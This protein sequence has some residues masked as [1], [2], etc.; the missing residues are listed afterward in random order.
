MAKPKQ[1]KPA[2]KK[3]VK[4]AAVEAEVKP[5]VETTPV[6]EE[7]KVETKENKESTRP[8]AEELRKQEAVRDA[9]RGEKPFFT[10]E[11]DVP[12]ADGSVKQLEISFFP[13]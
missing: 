9:V 4:P 13:Y 3:A 1:K 2:V 7:T 10:K 6:V 5:V 11:F 8:A 12:Q